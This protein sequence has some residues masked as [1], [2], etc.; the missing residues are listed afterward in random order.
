MM[1]QPRGCQTNKVLR[2]SIESI[3]RLIQWISPRTL[4]RERVLQQLAEVKKVA[5]E[6]RRLRDG[7]CLLSHDLDALYPKS[8]VIS[9]VRRRVRHMVLTLAQTSP[10][11]TLRA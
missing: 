1:S 6:S 4:G 11:G 3:E 5:R 9:L 2:E 10:Y 7:I 8:A